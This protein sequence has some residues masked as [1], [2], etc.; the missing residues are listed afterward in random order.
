MDCAAEQNCIDTAKVL[1]EAGA[2]V[3]GTQSVTPLH[4]AAGHESENVMILL[5]ENGANI[6]RQDSNGLTPL[7]YATCFD[8]FECVKV[9]LEKG[10]DTNIKTYEGNIAYTLATNTKIKNLLLKEEEKK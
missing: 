6:N 1:L 9:L 10:A 7:H 4:V 3:N 8:N 2:N 5:M